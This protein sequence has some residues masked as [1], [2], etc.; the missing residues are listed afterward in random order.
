[1]RKVG[2]RFCEAK[3]RRN[4]WYLIPRVNTQWLN[5]VYE[6]FAKDALVDNKKILLVEDNAGWHRSKSSKVPQGIEIEYLPPYS[7]E[8]QPAERLWSLVDEPLVNQYFESIEEIEDIL[9]QRCNF[10][11]QEMQEEIRKL[12]NYHWLNFSF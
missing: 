12:T 8:L 2:L 3:N 10:L 5:L 4:I 9:I 7:P 11:R 6:A 1:M